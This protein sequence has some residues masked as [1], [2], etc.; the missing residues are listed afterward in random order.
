ME[1]ESVDFVTHIAERFD[2]NR[3]D[4][5]AVLGCWLVSYEPLKPARM[6]I[7]GQL[8]ELARRRKRALT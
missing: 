3:T 4:A 5:L 1:Q 8:A 6:R 2:L 7:G